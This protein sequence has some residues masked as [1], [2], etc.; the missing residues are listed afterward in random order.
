MGFAPVTSVTKFIDMRNY[1]FLLNRP[2]HTFDDAAINAQ[3]QGQRVLVTGAGGSIGSALVRR[4]V[5]SPAAF[6]GAIGRSELP[7]F[8]LR[9]QIQSSKL[10]TAIV[11]ITHEHVIRE[12]L[13]RWQPSIL[14]NAAAYKH[15]GLMQGQPEQAFLNNTRATINLAKAALASN[16]VRRFVQISTD[17]AVMPSSVMGAS[18]RLAEAWLHKHAA[19]FA[20]ICR[21][22]NVLGSSGSLVEIAERKFAAGEPVTIT[23]PAMKRFFITAREAVGLVLSA[24]L[25]ESYADCYSINMGEPISILDVVGKLAPDGGRIQSGT[26]GS[27]EK[28]EEAILGPGETT[29]P[30]RNSALMRIFMTERAD[31]DATI[32]RIMADPSRIVEE[33]RQV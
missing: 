4:L 24:A 6:V 19:P 18:K 11:D 13:K 31:I 15:V 7:I 10:S 9:Q 17:K 33:A 22:G 29:A 16:S 21:F 32:A 1:A 30:A 5:D 8:N 23:D 26:P 28:L 14:I 12:L 2:E 3:L 25:M 27:G 20:T